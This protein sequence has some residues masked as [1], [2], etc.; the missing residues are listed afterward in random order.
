MGVQ[1]IIVRCPSLYNVMSVFDDGCGVKFV[2][3]GFFLLLL[4]Y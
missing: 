2:V 3:N 1:N 4:R